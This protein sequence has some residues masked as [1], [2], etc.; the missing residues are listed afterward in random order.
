M[1]VNHENGLGLFQGASAQF[2]RV[3]STGHIANRLSHLEIGE[4]VEAPAIYA[5]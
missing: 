4:D 5:L 1:R 3:A 2:S